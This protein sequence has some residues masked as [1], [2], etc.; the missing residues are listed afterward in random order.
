MRRRAFAPCF[1]SRKTDSGNLLVRAEQLTE[2]Q[3]FPGECLTL[4]G[5]SI[6]PSAAGRYFFNADCQL[7]TTVRGTGPS[8]ELT[9]W[10]TMKRWPSAVTS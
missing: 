8:G 2:N 6:I 9:G 10:N 4:A 5:G 7:S 3:T 1:G